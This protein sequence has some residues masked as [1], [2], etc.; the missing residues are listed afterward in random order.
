MSSGNLY[1]GHVLSRM[2]TTPTRGLMPT[3][4]DVRVRQEGLVM[5]QAQRVRGAI[6]DCMSA[7]PRKCGKSA[8]LNVYGPG[9]WNRA[10]L[11]VVLQ[12]EPIAS[13][14]NQQRLGREGG[15]PGYARRRTA[16]QSA[17]APTDPAWKPMAK[18]TACGT[19][20]GGSDVN[21]WRNPR[22][23]TLTPRAVRGRSTRGR[24]VFCFAPRH[25]FTPPFTPFSFGILSRVVD[26]T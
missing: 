22:T 18:A 4:T 13:S 24:Y 14:D 19:A 10:Q 15:N 21:D 6:V 17:R 20:S 11:K 23:E 3:V 9:G 2:G 25:G 1:S 5:L 8:G 7:V 16:Y 12:P 26:R